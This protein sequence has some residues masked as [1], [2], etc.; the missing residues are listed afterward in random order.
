MATEVTVLC[1]ESPAVKQ[2]DGFRC[3]PLG[4]QFY[5]RRKMAE[6]KVLKM[7]LKPTAGV[8]LKVP[9]DC[10][11]VVVHCR[12]EPRRRGLYRIWVV[13]LDLPEKI[14]R[15]IRCLSKSADFLCP[16]CENY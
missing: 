7:R 8:K 11:G 5:T 12:P 16:H 2:P 4:L 3:C 1:D 10:M 14:R 15:K 13:F 6:Y 9:I